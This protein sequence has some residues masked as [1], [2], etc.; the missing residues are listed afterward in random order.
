MADAN[1]DGRSF[2]RLEDERFLLG[3]GCYVEDIDVGGALHGYV[4]RSPHAHALIRRIDVARAAALPGVHL[5]ATAADL[6]ADGL[7]PLP[8]MAAVTPLVVPPRPALA[9]DRVRHVGDPVAFIVADSIEAA[10]EAAELVEVDYGPLPAVVD[11]KAALAAGAPVIW[12]QAPGN[13]AFHVHR[14]DAEAVAQAM[15]D[16]AHVVAI[17]VMNNRVIV[18]PLEPRAGIGR[19]DAATDTMDLELTGQGLHGIRRQLAEFVFKVPPERIQLHAPDVGGGFGMKNFLYPEWVLLLWAARR[20]GR[21]VR[22][23]AERAEDFVTGAQ[24]RDIAASARLALDASGRFLALDVAMVANLGAYLSGNGPGASVVAASTAQG[25]VY[26]IP[27]VAVEVHGA[28]TNTVPVD[29]YRGAG[30][31]EAN[32]IIER[33]IE[34]AARK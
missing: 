34:A 9:Q 17:E 1:R 8:C 33:A 6:A 11:G 16:A 28:F 25:G 18:V 21:P 12:E 27:A 19:Y 30:K 3:R 26:D 10:R 23:I 32:Y 15:K 2:R 4:L 31:P 14:G 29:A 7:G 24:G 22:W 13:L 20:L 5:V